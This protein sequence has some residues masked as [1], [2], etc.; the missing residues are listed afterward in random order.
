[1]SKVENEENIID[2][3]SK[4]AI[5]SKRRKIRGKKHKE[6]SSMVKD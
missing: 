2:V 3:I 6:G 5:A 1:M 4:T